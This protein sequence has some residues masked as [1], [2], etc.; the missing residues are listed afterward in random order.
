MKSSPG[1]DDDWYRIFDSSG[2][3]WIQSIGN[4]NNEPTNSKEEWVVDTRSRYVASRV[5][6]YGSDSRTPI[7][8]RSNWMGRATGLIP[9]IQ[10]IAVPRVFLLRSSLPAFVSSRCKRTIN[11]SVHPVKQIANE[12]QQQ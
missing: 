5:I 7:Q 8:P 10:R 9:K 6:I 12:E 3:G 2:A 11:Q 4:N 1:R